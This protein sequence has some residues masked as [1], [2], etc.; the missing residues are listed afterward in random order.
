MRYFF[1]IILLF[2]LASCATM[3]TSVGKDFKDDQINKIQKDISTK[4]DILELFGEPYS[5]RINSD[6]E[7]WT[8]YYQ[9]IKSTAQ[10]CLIITTAKAESEVK[11]LEVSF[12]KEKVSDY[13]YSFQPFSGSKATSIT[14]P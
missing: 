9:R 11:S 8:Y 1:G 13:S 7:T 5:K 4:A 14:E 3:N 2:T 6:N 10:S 12:S